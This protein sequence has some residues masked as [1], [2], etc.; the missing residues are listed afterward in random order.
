MNSKTNLTL[1]PK[2]QELVC[3]TDWIL[4]KHTITEKIITQF[5]ALLVSMQKIAE[6][7]KNDLPMVVFVTDPKISKGENYK[8]LPYIMLDYPRYFSKEN[9]LAIRTL[10]WWGNFFSVNLQLAGEIKDEAT[11]NLISHFSMLQQQGYWICSNNHPWDH[12]FEEGN[13]LPMQ[14][15]TKTQFTVMLSKESFVKIGKKISI[16]HW[17]TV[18]QFVEQTFEEMILILK[19]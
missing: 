10:F 15:I 12:Y 16:Q 13:Y 1:S 11:P 7:S 18:T 3:N 8:G 14:N 19:N 4:T 9:A 17:S 5:A 6:A 2:E